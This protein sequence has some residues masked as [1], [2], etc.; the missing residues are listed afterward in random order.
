MLDIDGHINAYVIPNMASSFTSIYLSCLL[1]VNYPEHSP[2]V[3]RL[4]HA[5]SI[6]PQRITNNRLLL[7]KCSQAL[8]HTHIQTHKTPTYA[9]T[10][11]HS[12]ISMSVQSKTAQTAQEKKWAVKSSLHSREK[13][14]AVA[15][16]II[17]SSIIPPP[18]ASAAL[19]QMDRQISFALDWFRLAAPAGLLVTF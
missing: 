6:N 2:P 14:K 4:R 16:L 19:R 15:I 9:G 10:V 5:L 11:F 18:S 8:N 12:I 17:P 13:E 3:C 7:I 1:L